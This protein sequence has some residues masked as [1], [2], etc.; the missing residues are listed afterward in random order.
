MSNRCL[1]ASL[2]QVDDECNLADPRNGKITDILA[3]PAEKALI[4]HAR[5]R[6]ADTRRRHFVDPAF[7]NFYRYRVQRSRLD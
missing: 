6:C 3:T 5:N 2:P 4:F 1:A 7:L